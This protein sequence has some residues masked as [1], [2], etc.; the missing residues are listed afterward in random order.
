MKKKFI[1]TEVQAQKILNLS[2]AMMQQGQLSNPTDP[3]FTFIEHVV[4][5]QAQVPAGDI[6]C[7]QMLIGNMVG[8]YG[9]TAG[10]GML[11]S[12]CDVAWS[13]AVLGYGHH[14]D[15]NLLLD[16]TVAATVPWYTGPTTMGWTD[17]CSTDSDHGPCPNGTVSPGDS[18]WMY[19][20]ECLG[21]LPAPSNWPTIT[22]TNCECCKDVTTNSGSKCDPCHNPLDFRMNG[23][24]MKCVEDVNNP[25]CCKGQSTVDR[26]CQKCC[27]PKNGPAYG[28]SPQPGQPCECPK[29]DQ[30]VP[31]KPVSTGNGDQPCPDVECENPNHVPNPSNKCKCECPGGELRCPRGETWD[32]EVC[33]CVGDDVVGPPLQTENR[34][35]KRITRGKLPRAPRRR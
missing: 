12:H 23:V 9:G 30:E 16:P 34:L 5:S 15:G 14:N 21:M 17:C 32:S 10:Q 25:G 27:K 19:C 29:K 1:I 35:R 4:P 7:C 11:T 22:G 26:P 24:C 2:E 20:N 33:R 13:Q 6:D 8:P 18:D 28:L 31:C 3:C